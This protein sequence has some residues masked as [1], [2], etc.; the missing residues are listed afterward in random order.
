MASFTWSL[1]GAIRSQPGS[2]GL[3]K[4]NVPVEEIEKRMDRPTRVRA[5]VPAPHFSQ[6]ELLSSIASSGNVVR[7]RGSTDFIARPGIV[8]VQAAWRAEWV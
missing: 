5:G 7:D 8:R 3:K 1:R 2:F 6:D 4:M